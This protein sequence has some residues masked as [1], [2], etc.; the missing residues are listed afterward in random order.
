MAEEQ[1]ASGDEQL[2]LP[3]GGEGMSVDAQGVPIIPPDHEET[4]Q[5]VDM[6]DFYQTVKYLKLES[7]C[8]E[9][10]KFCE[11]FDNLNKGC[12]C[13]RNKRVD[14]AQHLYIRCGNMG[15][16]IQSLLKES[17]NVDKVQF[18]QEAGLFA[19]F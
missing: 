9:I 19:E 2:G 15:P 14:H 6:V 18:F 4:R 1:L 5:I 13:T 7:S 8:S 11:A 3:F 10:S 16:E 17:L 12:G